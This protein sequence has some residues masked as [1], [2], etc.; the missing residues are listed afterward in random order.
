MS[1]HLAVYF[2]FLIVLGYVLVAIDDLVFDVVYWIESGRARHRNPVL[3]ETELANVPEARIAVFTAAWHEQDVIGQMLRFNE[4]LIDY[5]RYEIFVGTY[6]ND[7][8]TQLDVD[9]AAASLPRVH[10][11]VNPRPGPSTKADNLN[12]ILDGVRRRE[13]EVGAPFDLVMLH[14]PEDVI[15]P[16]ELRVVNWHFANR[17]ALDMI[18]L[19]I[20]PLPVAAHSFTAGTYLDEF[21]E[22]HTKD[23]LVREWIGGFVPSAGVATTWRRHVL[24]RLAA[25]SP[26][27]RAFSVNS[28]TEDYDIGLKIRL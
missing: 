15:H 17:P 28:L 11:V 23:I 26:D 5:D 1:N 25:T 13:A 19:P 6:P 18:Q 7:L 12:A 10:K 24:D 27:G 21:A 4:A 2:L 16:L 8:P 9:Q 22:L 3:D 14:D 20:L